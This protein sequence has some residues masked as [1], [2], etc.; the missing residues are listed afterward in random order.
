M[1]KNVLFVT[2]MNGRLDALQA[3]ILRVKL[4]DFHSK[5][6]PARQNTSDYYFKSFEELGSDLLAS[7]CIELPYPSKD[8]VAH[9]FAQF[10]V[11]VRQ[12]LRDDVIQELSL[13]KIPTAVHYRY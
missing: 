7:G 12:E 1:K 6:L 3:G 8:V 13:Q 9:A 5:L 2:G 11:R 4:R 10:T